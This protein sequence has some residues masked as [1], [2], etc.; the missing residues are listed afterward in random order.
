MARTPRQLKLLFKDSAL[1][2][3]ERRERIAVEMERYYKYLVKLGFDAPREVP[4]IG[5]NKRVNSSEF[6]SP[7]SIYDQSVFI[8]DNRLGDPQAIR[9]A[10]GGYAFRVLLGVGHPEQNDEL[11]RM[12]ASLIFWVY[13]EYSFSGTNGPFVGDGIYRWLRALWKIRQTCG[14]QFV[15]AAMVYTQKLVNEPRPSMEF[16]PWFVMRFG[17][18]ARVAE[19]QGEKMRIVNAALKAENLVH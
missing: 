13:F 11:Q 19:N 9:S 16:D 6:W 5:V 12:E 4:P 15:D 3:N 2:T 18:G 10:Y 14:S 17:R 1:L 7:G 8:G